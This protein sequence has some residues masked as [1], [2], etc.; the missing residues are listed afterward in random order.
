MEL[1]KNWEEEVEAV[2]DI[3]YIKYYME[4]FIFNKIQD[5]KEQL[6]ISG[7]VNS[8]FLFFFL[9]SPSFY[10]ETSYWQSSYKM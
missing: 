7:K 3:Y 10:H 9:F 5:E 1:G 4:M 6:I 8:L 2:I